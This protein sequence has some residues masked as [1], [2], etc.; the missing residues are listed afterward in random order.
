MS[1]RD[2][3]RWRNKCRKEKAK[4][5]QIQ[6]EHNTALEQGY[7]GGGFGEDVLLIVAADL[8]RSENEQL[9][10]AL[11]LARA[12]V[13]RLLKEKEQLLESNRILHAMLAKAAT[14]P[15]S[16]ATV[17]PPVLSSPLQE[18]PPPPQLVSSPSSETHEELLKTQLMEKMLRLTNVLSKKQ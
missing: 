8:A 2:V 14:T 9:T 18:N 13:A 3:L 5:L 17:V 4:R 7:F 6:D 11:E 10:I 12:N 15:M 1:C 16:P